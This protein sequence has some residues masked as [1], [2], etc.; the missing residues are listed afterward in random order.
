MYARFPPIAEMGVTT[1]F[2]KTWGYTENMLKMNFVEEFVKGKVL[3]LATSSSCVNPV[4]TATTHEL[5]N[6]QFINW[7]NK[8]SCF[9]FKT[10]Y[11]ALLIPRFF[12]PYFLPPITRSTDDRSDSTQL[13]CPRSNL[14][15]AP[16]PNRP[17]K[18]LQEGQSSM[19]IL[20]FLRQT[21]NSHS[22]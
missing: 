5:L 9:G 1:F 11:I 22:Q 6:G 21:V 14:L 3:I 20:L 15:A 19:K 13:R 4:H 18:L 16:L 12:K 8:F 7:N 10:C 17:N 2:T